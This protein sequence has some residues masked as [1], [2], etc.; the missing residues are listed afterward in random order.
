M[1]KATR[2]AVGLSG[3]MDS[4][5]AAWLLQQAGYEVTG[6][7]L[8]L[9][10]QHGKREPDDLVSRAAA[11]CDKLQIPHEVVG[12]TDT[13]RTC[14]VDPFLQQYANGRTPSPCLTC[15][16]YIKFGVMVEEARR[17]GC[18]ALATG[19]YA[20]V[21]QLPNG[22][23]CIVRGND[24]SKDQSYFLA[25]LVQNQLYAAVFPLGQWTKTS[26]REKVH[27]LGLV[28]KRRSE[29]QDLCFVP[30]GDYARFLRN[31]QS[32]LPGQGQIVDG[33]GQVLGTHKGFFHYTIGQRRGLGLGGGPW[34]VVNILPR[35]NRVVVGPREALHRRDCV[36]E[37][38]N[39][40]RPHLAPGESLA[41]DVQLRYR[42][43]AVPGRVHALEGRRVRIQL[44]TPVFAVTPGQAAV[45]YDGKRVVGSAWLQGTVSPDEGASEHC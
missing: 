6:I 7:T 42:M 24:S 43:R 19:H 17:H 27:E 33:S 36:A 34:Y 14:V 21:E 41:A 26:V 45:F 3:G 11:V 4:A 29:S 39:W 5:M 22:W 20:R 9:W 15:N 16:R 10:P 28:E 2:V 8:K 40:M 12:H 30:D 18:A 35:R 13:F 32:E 44:D 23:R 1:A 38:V 37:D 31:R 25:R